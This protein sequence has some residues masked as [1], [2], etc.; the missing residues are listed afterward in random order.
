M[1]VINEKIFFVCF[2]LANIA[3]KI[4]TSHT[5]STMYILNKVYYLTFYNKIM[6]KSSSH[7]SIIASIVFR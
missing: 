6:I 2:V 5:K 4:F 1:L 7:D 3:S